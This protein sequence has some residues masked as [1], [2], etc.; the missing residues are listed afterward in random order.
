MPLLCP[1]LK[2]HYRLTS[3]SGL[4]AL[5]RDGSV[6]RISHDTHDLNELSYLR[7]QRDTVTDYSE[8]LQIVTILASP[9]CLLLRL[10]ESLLITVNVVARCSF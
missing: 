9:L 4:D 7:D 10:S 3:N 5:Y 1:V 6:Q 2:E 8:C